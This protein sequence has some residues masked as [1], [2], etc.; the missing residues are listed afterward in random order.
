MMQLHGRKV[1]VE[2]VH[3]FQNP[4]S[5]E[6]MLLEQRSLLLRECARLL[7]YAIGDT[8][9]ADVMEQRAHA[10]PIQLIIADFHG[11]RNGTGVLT[12]AAAVAGCVAVA[13]IEGAGERPDEL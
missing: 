5:D 2:T 4:A 1:G 8:D 11:L 7:Q 9:L 12:D 13:G 10:D 3:S 6:G